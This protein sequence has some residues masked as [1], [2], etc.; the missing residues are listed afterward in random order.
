MSTNFYKDNQDLKFYI[1]KGID[2]KPLVE[3]TEYDFKKKD[4]FK[5]IDEALKFY[6]GVLDSI[7]EFAA[8]EVDPYTKEIDKEHPFLENGEVKFP[9]VLRNIFNKIKKLELYGM[10]LPLELGGMNCP[11]MVFMMSNELFARADV[12]VTAHYGFHGGMAM[13]MLFFSIIE[14]TTHFDAEKL[15]IKDTRFSDFISEIIDG[16][17]WGCMDI[18]EPDAGSDMAALNT[19]AHQDENGNWY[20]NGQK[21]FITSGHAKYHFVIARTEEKVDDDSFAGLKGLSMFLVPAWKTEQGKRITLAVFD[22]VEDKLGHHGSAT[23]SINFKDSPGYLIGKRGD[24]FKLM[25][26]IMNNARIGVG[27]EALGICESAWRMAKDYASKRHSMGKTI[28]KHEMI[29]DYLDE[30]YTDIQGIRALAVNAAYHEEMAQ[31]LNLKLKFLPPNNKDEYKSIEDQFKSHQARARSI[32]PLLKYLGAEKAVEISKRAIQIHGGYGYTTEYGVEKLLR[33]AMVLPIYEGTSQ[34]QSLMAMKDN[35]TGIIKDPKGFF[36]KNAQAYWI[37]KFGSSVM[38]KRVAKL[39]VI[40]YKILKFLIYNLVGK[41]ISELRT[42]PFDKWNSF[43]KSWDPK[44]DFALAMLHAERLTR[45]LCD[46]A[47]CELLLEQVQKNPERSDVLDRYLER[48]ECRCSYLYS[49]I[50]K[51]G[52]RLLKNLSK[53]R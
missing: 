16:K 12:S 42:Q 6:K 22:G 13:A 53:K 46:V 52:Q 21:I 47:V 38:E 31:K 3:L 17:A 24:G 39:Q 8:K 48:A 34:I 1:E 14:E 51:T 26:Q 43:F 32:T 35:L 25:L 9:P 30:M 29:A 20:I 36:A 50:T 18:T 45:V 5:N 27:F 40:S 11:F 28:D 10:A 44:K 23:V 19:K 4:G 41:K 15:Q 33:D 37:S 2:W 7:G 49:E